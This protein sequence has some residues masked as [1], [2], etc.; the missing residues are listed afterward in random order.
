MKKCVDCE[1]AWEV[2]GCPSATGSACEWFTERE[3]MTLAL[4]DEVLAKVKKRKG[5]FG[6]EFSLVDG[7]K[8]LVVELTDSDCLFWEQKFAE[9]WD[10]LSLATDTL[11]GIKTGAHVSGKIKVLEE[12]IH[13]EMGAI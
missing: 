1:W 9:M 13:H 10:A 3:P 7:E 4:L 12:M 11:L 8:M 2:E 5:C 6:H